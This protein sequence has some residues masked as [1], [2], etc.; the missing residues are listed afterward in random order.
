[1]AGKQG[2]TIVIA[3]EDKSGE[4]FN[5]VSKHLSETKQKA[6]ETGESLKQM[7]DVLKTGLEVAGIGLG[8]REVVSQMKD[9]V[10]GAAE[11]G[12]KIAQANQRTGIAAGTL[13]VLH[14]A[15][16]T[17]GTDFDRL[18]NAVG[19][20]GKSMAD[21]ADGDKKKA[22]AF[23][24][25]GVEARDLAGRSDGLEVALGKL[26][27]GLDAMESPARRNQ[28]AIELLGK[29]GSADIPVLKE[30]AGHFDELKQKT[31]ESGT[32]M[33]EMSAAQLKEL[34]AKLRDL[35]QRITGAKIA[36]AEGLSPALE[37]II[38]EFTASSG[39]TNIWN[40]AGKQAGVVAIEVAAAFKWLADFIRE[41]KDEYINLSSAVNAFDYNIGSKFNWSKKYR[42]EETA[43]RDASLKAMRD[44]KTDHDAMLAEESRFV[45]D[46]KQLESRLMNPAATPAAGKPGSGGAGR[47]GGED[48]GT[49]GAGGVLGKGK[50]GAFIVNTEELEAKALK[51]HADFID[52]V[53]A[54]NR[55][56]HPVTLFG[57]EDY[58]KWAAMQ[59]VTPNVSA[60]IPEVPLEQLTL[61]PLQKDYTALRDA[62]EKA[63][64]AVFDPLFDTS[65]R[66]NQKW[67][68]ISENLLRNIAQM[69]EGQ[70][71]GMLFGDPDGRGG[72]GLSGGSWEG[73]PSQPG[74][75]TGLAS[76]ALDAIGGLFH[77]PKAGVTSNG[78]VGAGAG[79]VATAAA[80]LMQVGKASGNSGVQV[81]LNNQGAPLQATAT[82]QSVTDGAE[83][84]VVQI[85]LKQLETNGPVAQGIVGMMGLL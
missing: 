7:G 58:A 79:T 6:H 50:G 1:M 35:E 27:K 61:K 43:R 60:T 53:D 57:P 34:N 12:E 63:A 18:V 77:H 23:H 75:R 20:M 56:L 51:E 16:A 52:K 38:K 25:I 80:S 15:A 54:L 36:F 13:S 3:G 47:G 22:E 4:V 21:A 32:Y 5:A 19:K 73:N 65:E 11:F 28:L 59:T 30:L 24:A 45:T 70:V 37:G 76:G 31:I 78:G 49:G 41:T 64:H 26:G 82:Q 33:N 40:A 29:A 74:K 8:L 67:K 68:S 71:F 9:A 72:R 66:W 62:G 44:S 48:G 55:S 39:E 10:N 85:V 42:D 84:Q 17:T 2:V 46:M 69:A 81:V 14:Y 83:Q